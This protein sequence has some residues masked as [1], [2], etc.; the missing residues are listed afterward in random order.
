MIK[1]PNKKKIKD[2]A[3]NINS[4]NN[5]TMVKGVVKKGMDLENMINSTN[6]YYA[7]NNIAFIYKKPTPIKVNKVQVQN[8]FGVKKHVIREAYFS[9]KSTTDYSGLYRG[10]YVDFEVKQTKYK[11]FNIGSNLHEH[12]IN[13]LRNIYK[14]GGLAYL[15]VYFYQFDTVM[16]IDFEVLDRE[17]IEK[18]TIISYDFFL[19]KAKEIEI[20]YNPMLDYVK[21]IDKD[22]I[23]REKL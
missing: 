11:T 15:I 9:E 3:S 6:Q 18:K 5:Q 20:G 7:D 13:H 22:I 19:D 21:V 4:N 8:E 1:Y 14:H 12:Q 16:M 2:I 23:N 17:V 10:Y